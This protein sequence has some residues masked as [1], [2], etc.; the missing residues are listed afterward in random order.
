VATSD[1][2][3]RFRRTQLALV[4]P[5]EWLGNEED[6]RAAEEWARTLNIVLVGDGVGAGVSANGGDPSGNAVLLLP[7]NGQQVSGVIQILGRAASPD[8]QG[9][10]L[11]WGVGD[12]P[13][14]WVSI[15]T[16]PNEVSTGT[17]GAWNTSGLPDG[18]YTLR[19]TVLDKEM[20]ELHTQV[21]VVI[22]SR[23]SDDDDD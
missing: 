2:P 6:K 20:G 12:D 19:L 11:E 16:N 15:V 7:R 14:E 13:D 10:L 22:G 18:E 3:S 8:F 1:T 5:K 21:T 17:I 9:Y 23:Q 4:P